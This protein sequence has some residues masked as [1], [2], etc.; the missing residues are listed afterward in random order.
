M[1]TKSYDY[2]IKS[3]IIQEYG[4]YIKRNLSWWYKGAGQ[5]LS[6]E[7]VSKQQ[8]VE[9]NLQCIYDNKQ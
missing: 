1:R 5:W 7:L 4:E 3:E 2:S 6:E 9:Y 8:D